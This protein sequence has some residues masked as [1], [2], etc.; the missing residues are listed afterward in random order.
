MALKSSPLEVEPDSRPK[1]SAQRGMPFHR[2]VFWITAA[3]LLALPTVVIPPEG[4]WLGVKAF[5]LEVSG[6]ILAVLVVSR[7]DWTASRVRS[8]LLA[9]VNLAVLGFLAWVGISAAIA[10]I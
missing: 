1:N 6:I 8:A 5:A 7:G 2:L 3:L 9:P 4:V 10:S